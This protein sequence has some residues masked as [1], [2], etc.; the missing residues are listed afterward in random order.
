MSTARVKKNLSKIRIFFFLPSHRLSF[1]VW[2][3]LKIMKRDRR[4]ATD[5]A[6]YISLSFTRNSCTQPDNASLVLIF[7]FSSALL[8]SLLSHRLRSWLLLF[9]VFKNIVHYNSTTT[10]LFQCKGE[11][12]VH[13]VQNIGRLDNCNPIWTRH[14]QTKFSDCVHL[15][16]SLVPYR[17]QHFATADGWVM[18]V[19]YCVRMRF[20]LSFR[21]W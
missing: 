9:L 8:L 3:Q 14:H 2:T 19:Y 12:H 13:L 18:F 11:V 1:L 7:V 10:L 20:R 21:L 5:K 16:H 4:S 15:W 17:S 6:K